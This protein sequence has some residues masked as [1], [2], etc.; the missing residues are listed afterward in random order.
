[1]VDDFKALGTVLEAHYKAELKLATGNPKQRHDQA[2]AAVAKRC[3][4]L[5][6]RGV[7]ANLR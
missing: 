7:L 6:D 1:M 4:E 5:I 2:W 3:K